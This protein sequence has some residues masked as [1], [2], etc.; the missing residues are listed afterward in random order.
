MLSPPMLSLYTLLLRVGFCHTQGEDYAETI[1]KITGGTVPPYQSN[2]KSQLS[3]AQQGIERILKY[4]YA[5]IFFK[6]PKKNYPAIATSNMHH[7]T[8]IC[9]FSG[10]ASKSHVG[11]WHRDLDQPK[12]DK[13]K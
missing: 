9:S 4:G 7:H 11:H 8:G 2:D 10:G 1:K 6:D 3:S 12:S 13:K 5:K